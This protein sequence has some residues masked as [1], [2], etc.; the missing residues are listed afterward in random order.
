[1]VLAITPFNYPG[2]LAIHKIAPAL[3]AGNAVVLKPAELTP[4]TALALADCFLEAGLP[5]AVL[6]VVTGHGTE[7]GDALVA[8]PRVRKVSFTGSTAVG[9]RISRTAGVKKLSLELGS[10]SPVVILPDADLEVA[11]SAVAAGGYANAGQVCISV[12][13]VITHP[14]VTGDFLDALVPARRGHP[15]RRP[16]G[17]GHD[18]GHADQRAEA[19]RV[20]RMIDDAAAA[21][22]RVL[23]GG[24]REGAVVA[25]TVVADVDPSSPLH[26]EELFGPAVAV[27]TA[28]DWESAIAQANGTSYGLSAGIFTGDVAGAVRAI[29]EIDAGNVHIN[30]TPL[31]RADL[32]PYGGLKGS[33][34]RQGGPAAGGGGDDGGEDGRAPRSS[35]VRALHPRDTSL[36]N[37]PRGTGHCLG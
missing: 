24:S 6:S 13:R 7:I 22:A 1:M 11:A 4:L 36:K 8:D 35:L 29:R 3:A 23:V 27:S 10:S 32:M 12:Q 21:G 9:E 16:G 15:H 2:L 20:Q 37:A 14:A 28:A 30:W 31:W 33:G 25:P 34:Y 17:A 19:V 18:D 5:G 26:Q